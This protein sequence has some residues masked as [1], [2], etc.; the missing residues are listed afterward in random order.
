MST[1]M[2]SQPST[3]DF[4]TRMAKVLARKAKMPCYVGNSIDLHAAAGGGSV[5]EEMEVF[6]AIIGVVTEALERVQVIV[7]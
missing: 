7:N 4:T 1:T 5:E 3:L 6:R 2:Y